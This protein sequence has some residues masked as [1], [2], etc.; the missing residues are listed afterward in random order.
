MKNKILNGIKHYVVDTTGLLLASTPV[1]AAMET[2]VSGM[3]V[4]TSFES[5]LKVSMLAYSGLGIVYAKGR[6]LSRSLFGIKEETPEWKKIVHDSA[7][8]VAFNIP[9]AT[10]IYRT[11]G[12][13]IEQ[14]AKGVAGASVLGLFSG[15]LNGYSIDTFRDFIGTKESERK[16]PKIIK[17]AERKTKRALAV[18]SIIGMVATTAGIY[19]VKDKFFKGEAP[20]KSPCLETKV[21]LPIKE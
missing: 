3:S 13:N 11:S 14:T 21:E 8:N 9:M 19:G 15:P 17:N 18:A 7:Y 1:Y 5:R 20:L 16:M 4:A 2:F 6:D 12:A 10:I